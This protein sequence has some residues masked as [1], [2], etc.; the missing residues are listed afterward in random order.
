MSS[1]DDEPSGAIQ[2]SSAGNSSL[3][4]KHHLTQAQSGLRSYIR[5]LVFNA[6][7]ADDLLQDVAVTALKNAHRFDPTGSV[8]A[9]VL[10]IARKRIMK[11][12][13]QRRRQK[14]AFSTELIEALTAAAD[15]EPECADAL[16]SLQGCLDKL[17]T[18]KRELLLKRHRAGVT[19]R[20]LA[21]E[22]GFSDSRMSRLLNS[23]YSALL[24]CV[25]QNHGSVT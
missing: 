8:G 24:K 5:S 22:S 15:N 18:R 1:F 9:W 16:E 7:D 3:L 10:G 20:Q 12:H 11:Y 19:A 6:A 2:T 17:D 14:V 13:E 21:R 25:E 4:V 23:L